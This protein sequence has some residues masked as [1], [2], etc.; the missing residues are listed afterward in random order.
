MFFKRNAVFYKKSSKGLQNLPTYV[1]SKVCKF[2]EDFFEKD[3]ALKKHL[4]NLPVPLVKIANCLN[5]L[6]NILF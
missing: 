5:F 2:F 1:I 6:K 4:Q 3:T